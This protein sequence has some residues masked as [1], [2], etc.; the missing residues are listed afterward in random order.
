MDEKLSND[1]IDEVLFRKTYVRQF[2]YLKKIKELFSS[3]EEYMVLHC[4][5]SHN[6]KDLILEIKSSGLIV[7]A[8]LYIKNYWDSLINKKNSGV[9]IHGISRDTE[10]PRTTVKRWTNSLIQRGLIIKNLDGYLVPTG[11]IRE[12]CKDL[13]ELVSKEHIDF[14]NF[15]SSLKI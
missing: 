3:V 8:D 2:D 14:A 1:F 15:Y 6:S 12:Y 7:D 5:A 11:L 10:I 13:R 9:S 4:I